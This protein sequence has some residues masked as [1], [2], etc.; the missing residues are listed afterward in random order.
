MTHVNT[1]VNTETNGDDDVDTT[2]HLDGDVPGVH[3]A[4]EV[5]ETEADCE[6]DQDRAEEISEE[7][8]SGEEDTDECNDKI[9]NQLPSDNIISLPV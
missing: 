4:E 3:V 1:V 2:D 9:T 6:E 8:E 7:E 5:D